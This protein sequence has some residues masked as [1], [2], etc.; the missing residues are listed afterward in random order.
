MFQNVQLEMS[1]KPF[2]TFD[3][4]TIRRVCRAVFEQWRP[5]AKDAPTVSIMLWTADGSEILDYKGNLDEPFE[6]C[7]YVGGGD[8]KGVPTS[9]DPEAVS[10][11]CSHYWYMDNPPTVT[12]RTLKKVIGELRR[13][14]KEILGEDKNILIGETFDVGPEFAK[15]SFKYP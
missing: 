8:H 7:Y 3:D 11:N 1:L 9:K 5:L 13:A 15:S 12:Y 2:R 4:E 14:G 6:W 10:L